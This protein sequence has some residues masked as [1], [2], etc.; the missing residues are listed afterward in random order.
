MSALPPKEVRVELPF[1]PWPHQQAAHAM[2][3]AVRF[4]VLV[5]HRR[6][7]K[8]VWCVI[9]LILAALSATRERARYA[10]IAPLLKQSKTVAWD[11]VRAFARCVP[12]TVVNESELSVTFVNGAQV[13]LHGADNPDGLRGIYLDGVVLDEVA[14]MKPEV[15]GEIVRP[16]LADRQGWACF[17]GTP[18][19]INLFSELYYRAEKGDVEGW[20]CDLRRAEDTGVI[21]EEELAQARAEMSP[22][23]YA[24]EFGVDFQ[25]AV[26]DVLIRLDAVL[27]AQKRTITEHDTAWAPRV[28]GVDVARYGGDRSVLFPRQG[29]VAFKP[30]VFRGLDTMALAGQVALVCERWKPDAVFVDVGGV[31][32]GVIDRLLQLKVAG[33][34]PVDFGSRAN[35]PRFENKR[36]EMWWEMAEWVKHGSLPEGQDL[37]KDLCAPRYTYANAR[38]RVQLESKDDMRER[39]LPSPDVADALACTFAYPVAARDLASKAATGKAADYDPYEEA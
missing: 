7:G 29:L 22:A 9:E 32:A 34:V 5:W 39:G 30:H 25:A 23:Q 1:S 20:A 35:S 2:R 6:A 15:W 28:L 14:D 37:Q 11:Y 3:L 8:T 13:R 18:K 16:A 38:G 4:L 27:E 24:Q 19:G 26:E 33:V 12:G 21:P 36:A 31:G 10:Y 17:I